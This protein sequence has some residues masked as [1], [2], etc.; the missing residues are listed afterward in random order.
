MS[1]A[2][3]SRAGSGGKMLRP[4]RVAR[5]ATPYDRPTNQNLRAENPGWISKL[6]IS[7]TLVIAS[8]AGKLL[9]SVFGSESSSSSSSSGSGSI[10]GDEIEDNDG[11]DISSPTLDGRDKKK[12]KSESDA[13]LTKGA[14]QAAVTSETKLLIEQLL[15]QETFSW[16]ECEK[17][18]NIIKSRVVEAPGSLYRDAGRQ[19]DVYGAA[20]SDAEMPHLSTA[21]MEV[22]KWID[23]KKSGSNTE[24]HLDPSASPHVNDGEI[25]SP[26]DLAKS[27]MKDRPSW[28]SP[29]FTS[30]AQRTAS[31]IGTRLFK[32]GGLFST[33]GNH[34][35]SSKVQLK[36]DAP[37][38]G[39]WNIS[40]EIR[41]V[42]SKATE[43]LLRTPSVK[44]DLSESKPRSF[45]SAPNILDDGLRG[46]LLT[47][48]GANQLDIEEPLI[49][50]PILVSEQNKDLDG[51]MMN[52]NQGVRDGVRDNE[53]ILISDSFDVDGLTSRD[54]NDNREPDFLPASFPKEVPGTGDASLQNGLLHSSSGM[55]GGDVKTYNEELYLPT[56]SLP[57][58]S[59]TLH[60]LKEAPIV[61]P[62][63]PAEFQSSS[64]M[65]YDELWQGSQQGQLQAATPKRGRKVTRLGR[66]GRGRGK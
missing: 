20:V 46:G 16:E 28:T 3:R 6:I 35:S 17:L 66:R 36:K 13:H 5:V 37:I 15:L 52:G 30:E 21:L 65:L 53:T 50:P 11:D 58:G 29:C 19:S 62:D 47:S 26:V 42:R 7:P 56:S 64:S 2:S 38:I 41:R 25:G 4:R 48:A 31:P 1:T 43:Q 23:E 9:S 51:K 8:G 14:N 33:S 10:S 59:E 55:N 60:S 45:A 49:N 18:T 12:E 44:I 61:V 22:K 24:L 40:E 54:T 39:S 57:T 63:A 27:F 34:A 32:D